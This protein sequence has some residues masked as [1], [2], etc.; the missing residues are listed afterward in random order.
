MPS[1][2]Q[3]PVSVQTEF[4]RQSAQRQLSV[5][6]HMPS[7]VQGAQAT[8]PRQSGHAQVSVARSQKP[9]AIP[10]LHAAA[11]S[12][13]WLSVAQSAQLQPSVYGSHI[14]SSTQFPSAGSAQ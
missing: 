13:Q 11:L 8:V 6:A 14:A 3:L 5:A 2:T 10:P 1:S 12:V 4:V 7:S 9:S